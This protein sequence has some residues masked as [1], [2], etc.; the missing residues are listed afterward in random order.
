MS[1]KLSGPALYGIIVLLCSCS[2]LQVVFLLLLIVYCL[3]NRGYADPRIVGARLDP[4]DNSIVWSS[5]KA[6]QRGMRPEKEKRNDNRPEQVT[7]SRPEH[8]F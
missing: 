5:S 3:V 4:Q 6:Q 2:A 7:F 8:T 1:A